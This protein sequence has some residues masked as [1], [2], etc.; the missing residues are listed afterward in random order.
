M[1]APRPWQPFERFLDTSDIAHLLV[2]S[3]GDGNHVETLAKMKSVSKYI[4]KSEAM[5]LVH[6]KQKAK[7]S[8]FFKGRSGALE[9]IRAQPDEISC[10]EAM[11][12]YE[13]KS[14]VFSVLHE[15]VRSRLFNQGYNA[16]RDEQI[17]SMMINVRCFLATYDWKFFCAHITEYQEFEDILEELLGHVLYL[18]MDKYQHFSSR[19]LSAGG[20]TQQEYSDQHRLI[21]GKMGDAGVVH[22]LWRVCQCHSTNAD[23]QEYMVRILHFMLKARSITCVRDILK[24]PGNMA[25]FHNVLIPTDA[26]AYMPS[27]Y[28]KFVLIYAEFVNAMFSSDPVLDESEE[29]AV[30]SAVHS[31]IANCSGR[32]VM[33]TYALCM[34]L[35]S[36][37]TRTRDSTLRTLTDAQIDFL[38]NDA[39]V[40]SVP[41][42]TQYV[43]TLLYR[44]LA[45]NNEYDTTSIDPF[46][47]RP[48]T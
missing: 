17:P 42:A 24:P 44:A 12:S 35:E 37:C 38:C 25:V 16:A 27:Y 46:F 8:A 26:G 2:R 48:E 28:Q 9:N 32:G 29:I 43:S 22:C 40:L 11:R 6:R 4:H 47:R 20:M 10:S 30:V 14:F 13:D 18:V 33:K 21:L 41:V 1:A 45:A 5:K 7:K 19:I 15:M 31:A 34:L 3:S 39:L 23:L 36:I